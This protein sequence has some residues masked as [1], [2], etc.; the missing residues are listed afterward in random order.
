MRSLKSKTPRAPAKGRARKRFVTVLLLLLTA[1]AAAW[2]LVGFPRLK[3]SAA[4]D[5]AIELRR[6]LYET[7][8]EQLGL[9]PELYQTPLLGAADVDSVYQ[10]VVIDAYRM[11]CIRQQLFDALQ[12]AYQ[13]AYAQGLRA[14]TDSV[15]PL[16]PL[17]VPDFYWEI[18]PTAAPWLTAEL[19]QS[20]EQGSAGQE[21]AI[22]LRLTVHGSFV[23]AGQR[24]SA[25]LCEEILLAKVFLRKS[26]A[27]WEE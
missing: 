3:A 19:I 14:E 1:A 9:A 5:Y 13:T 21:Y 7:V 10:P 6:I 18:R 8:N 16:M 17:F 22:S 26:A 11:N 24:T 25:E 23:V 15:L 2:E 4:E 27:L 20:S 12:D